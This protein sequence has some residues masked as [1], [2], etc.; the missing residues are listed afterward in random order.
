MGNNSIDIYIED[1]ILFVR[2]NS[3]FVF[4]VNAAKAITKKRVEVCNGK[5]FPTLFDYGENSRYASLEARKYFTNNG[6]EYISAA[7]FYTC[8]IAS[9]LFINSYLMVH[10]SIVPNKVFSNKTAAIK[11]LKQFV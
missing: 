7:A 3:K 6:E 5:P 9:R 2:A 8:D 11:W 1:G 10:Q 4:D